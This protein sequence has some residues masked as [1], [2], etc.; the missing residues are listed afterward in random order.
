VDHR[1]QEGAHLSAGQWVLNLTS[2]QMSRVDWP[3]YPPVA[4]M[5]TGEQIMQ[6]LFWAPA[7]N[8]WVRIGAQGR[9][10][11]GDVLCITFAEF[12]FLSQFI[13]RGVPPHQALSMLLGS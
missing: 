1:G 10:V 6:L 3:G 4:V 13:E 7:I 5:P 9:S 8:R 12:Q 2:V 11:E